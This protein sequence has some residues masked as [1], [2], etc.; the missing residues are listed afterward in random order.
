MKSALV[1]VQGKGGSC[2]SMCLRHRCIHARR[3][4]TQNRHQPLRVAHA[5]RMLVE[6]AW[7]YRFPAHQTAHLKRKVAMYHHKRALH[8]AQ[9]I[10][11]G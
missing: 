8:A 5:R 7:S 3:A 4:T 6:L 11:L 2:T 9:L 10:F 1:V